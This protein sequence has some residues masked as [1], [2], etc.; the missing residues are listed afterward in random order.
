MR[1]NLLAVLLM[2]C[3]RTAPVTITTSVCVNVQVGGIIKNATAR[4]SLSYATTAELQ[5]A[6]ADMQKRAATP[7]GGPEHVTKHGRILSWIIDELHRRGGAD[8]GSGMAE[9]TR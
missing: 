6:H 2:G 5:C 9:P 7:D 4:K 3:V 8:A 1:L